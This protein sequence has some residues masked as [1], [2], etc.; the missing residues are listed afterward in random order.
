MLFEADLPR[1]FWA[2]AVATAN[3]LRNRFPSRSLNEKTPFEGWTRVQAE[4][5]LSPNLWM[6]RTRTEQKQQARQNLTRQH[7]SVFL[8]D[9]LR[10]RKDIGSGY[11]L[12]KE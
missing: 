5:V 6:Q 2:K 7:E 12:K 3:H 11:R 4:S 10:S 8:L 1:T 9:I